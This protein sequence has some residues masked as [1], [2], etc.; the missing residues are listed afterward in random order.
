MRMIKSFS[1]NG[2]NQYFN[3]GEYDENLYTIWKSG[4][5][6]IKKYPGNNLFLEIRKDKKYYSIYMINTMEFLFDSDRK[7][8]KHVKNKIKHYS[9]IVKI[10]P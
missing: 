5:W 4:K 9:K 6:T 2:V 1:F 3:F 8:P 7:I 10:L